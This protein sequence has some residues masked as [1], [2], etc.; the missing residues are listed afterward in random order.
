MDGA[1]VV[2]RGVAMSVRK[3]L[4]ALLLVGS[5]LGSLV[6]LTGCDVLAKKAVEGA[7]GVKVDQNGG[8]V[9]VTTKDGEQATVSSGEDGKLP[10][11]LPDYVPVH[12]GKVSGKSAAMETPQGATYTFVVQTNDDIATIIT[13]AKAQL[14]AKGWTVTTNV[15]TSDSAVVSAKIGEKTQYTLTVTKGKTGSN[16]VATLVN[17]G[18]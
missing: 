13:W 18:K 1:T 15:T 11:G 7:T 12:D 14:T 2:R 17:V 5:L 4:L 6:A 9:T 10:S 8:K 16:E 3:R